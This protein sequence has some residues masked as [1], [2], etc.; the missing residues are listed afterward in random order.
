MQSE[1]KFSSI[2]LNYFES[3]ANFLETI[4]VLIRNAFAVNVVR[5][6]T[7][8]TELI[9]NN[10]ELF[11]SQ[12][13]EVERWQLVK[14]FFLI[15]TI[16]GK[17]STS[18]ARS[19]D[20]EKLNFY[21]RFSQ[22]TYV[23]SIELRFTIKPDEDDTD[24][25]NRINIPLLVLE[26]ATLNLS[27]IASNIKTTA[28]SDQIY[29]I[30]FSFKIKFVKQPNLDFLFQIVL[31]I[32]SCI[33]FFVALIQTFFYKIRQ[34]KVEYDFA[35][36]LNFFINVLANISN[37]FFAFILVFIAYVFF[38]YKN[39]D[40]HVKVMLSLKREEGIIRS[41]LITALVFKVTK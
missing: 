30:D 4:P 38:I 28:L 3:Q 1:T 35:I 20:D 41:L 25:E 22:I 40:E 32:F 27:Q 9:W 2:H 36:L 8:C 5:A 6:W 15:D 11:L 18:N 24:E 23:K 19:D 34:Q 13:E 10:Y 16:S 17:L 12:G 26:Y 37:A 7:W 31:P 14:R 29:N 39:Q 33:S 21:E